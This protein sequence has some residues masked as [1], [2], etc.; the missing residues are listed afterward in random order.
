M[1]AAVAPAPGAAVLLRAR[2]LALPVYYLTGVGALGAAATVHAANPG[3]TDVFIA[4]TMVALTTVV[5][6]MEVAGARWFARLLPGDEGQYLA[7]QSEAVTRGVP[8]AQ[9]ARYLAQAIAC[10]FVVGVATVLAAHAGGAALGGG[11]AGAIGRWP[12]ALRVLAAFVALDAWSYARHRLEHAGGER[13]AL[14]RRVHRAH[15]LPTAMNL[16]TGMVV[17]PVEAV[18]V[19]AAPTFAFG[20]LGYARWEVMLLFALFLVITM[21]QHMNSGWT[22]GPLGAVIHGPEAHTAHHSADAVER[23]ANYADCLTVWDRLGGT[24]REAGSGVFRGPFGA[25]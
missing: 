2:H 18:L 23:N 13:G 7:A 25:G 17:H 11:S 1:S 4:A 12:P 6:A 21:P 20:A 3:A 22:A 9:R 24:Y 15:H 14:W 5:V 19:F 8:T 16:W 10:W